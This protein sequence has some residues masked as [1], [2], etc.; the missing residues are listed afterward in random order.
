MKIILIAVG[1]SE[2]PIIES[3]LNLMPDKIIFFV[4]KKSRTQV[5]DKV[6]P[7]LISA[8]KKMIDHE[9]VQTEDEENIGKSA[10][11]LLQEVPKTMRKFGADREWPN[12]VD[13]TCG[14]KTM[15]AAMVW[16]SSKY[17]CVFNYV[18][19]TRRDKNGL[20][21]VQNG[22]ER[23]VSLQNPW[24]ELAYFETLD[25]MRL[26]DAGEYAVSAKLFE[27]IVDKISN[28]EIKSYISIVLKLVKAYALWDKF[29]HYAAFSEFRK[30]IESTRVL[31]N[32]T[33]PYYDL[34]NFLKRARENFETLKALNPPKSL[35]REMVI[36]LLANA[37]RRAE[38]EE[39]FEDAT[40]RTYSAIEKIAKLRLKEKYNIDTSNCDPEYIPEKIRDTYVKSYSTPEGKLKFGCVTAYYLLAELNDEVGIYFTDN[41]N[42]KNHLKARNDS[43]LAHGTQA[44]DKS[45]F[46]ALF[47]DALAILRIKIKDLPQF[48]KFKIRP[49][50]D[51]LMD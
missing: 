38:L 44:I 16:A 21:V 32:I 27:K 29:D 14:T 15:G 31:E 1:G 18:G 30:V 2:K 4:S 7:A 45:K 23:L 37:L 43:I 39:K 34:S 8:I 5:N 17:P 25:A 19:G 9:F 28:Q 42:I 50:N 47:N 24:D 13:Y 26:F 49:A 11:I 6:I 12:I 40:A 36:D 48:P 41:P 33:N 10:K 22:Y 51:E 35:S 46:E 20:G 3:I